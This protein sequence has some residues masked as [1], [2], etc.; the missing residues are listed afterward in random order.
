MNEKMNITIKFSQSAFKHGVTEEDILN[1]VIN[2]V[3]DDMLDEFDD[4]YLMIGFDGK[5]KLLEIV[6]HVIDNETIHVFH[7]MKC[8]N[9]FIDLFKN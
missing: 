2:V 3:Y 5:G 1:V 8:R 4:K 6:Y 9:S 7:A